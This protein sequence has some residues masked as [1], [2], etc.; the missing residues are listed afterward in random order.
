MNEA[1][2]QQSSGACVHVEA[3]LD[4]IGQGLVEA[5]LEGG[6]VRLY[7]VDLPRAP[8]GRGSSAALLLPLEVK[9]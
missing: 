9:P 2:P 3:I 4:L 8:T 6:E 1:S 5:R 7:P